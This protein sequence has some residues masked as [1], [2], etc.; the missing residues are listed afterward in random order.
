MRKS[1]P[2]EWEVRH[3]NSPAPAWDES[4]VRFLSLVLKLSVSGRGCVVW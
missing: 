1:G 3:E 2:E 4:S